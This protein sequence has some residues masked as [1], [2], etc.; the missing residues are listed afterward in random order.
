M[1]AVAVDTYTRQCMKSHSPGAA[2]CDDETGTLGRTVCRGRSAARVSRSDEQFAASELMNGRESRPNNLVCPCFTWERVMS[3]F[4]LGSFHLWTF[5]V[6]TN[7]L[8]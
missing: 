3:T 2:A 4:V 6:P 8:V 1:H 5:S 7:M